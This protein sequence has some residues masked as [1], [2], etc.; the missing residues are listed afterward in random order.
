MYRRLAILSLFLQNL[1][2]R[3]THVLQKWPVIPEVEVPVDTEEAVEEAAVEGVAVAS[4]VRTPL[5]WVA[6]AAGKGSTPPGSTDLSLR[7][8]GDGHGFV[9]EDTP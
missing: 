2:S 3:L 7:M 6:I 8:D 1:S 9:T 4:Q 5:P